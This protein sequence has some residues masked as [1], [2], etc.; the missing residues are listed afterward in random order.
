MNTRS[1][2]LSSQPA[3]SEPSI[4][5]SAPAT[6]ALAMSPEYCSP[7]SP[8]TG[9][10]A[11]LARLRRL[12]DRGHL[13]H[14]D[15]GDHAGGADRAGPDADLHAVRPGVDQRLRAASRVATLPPTTSTSRARR[16]RPSA[17]R[18]CP[19]RRVEWPFAV[20]TTSTST[21]ASTSAIARFQ[22]SSKKPIA[23]PT[24]SRPAGSLVASGYCSL[25]VKS[26]TVIRPLQPAR[27]VDQRQLLDLVLGAAARIA[28]VA[29]DADRGR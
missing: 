9:T 19:A 16:A 13:R 6:S 20:S 7:P 1:P 11:G 2:G 18:S 17:A 27:V 5:V 25:L 4:T 3:S 22:A 10:P 14:A 23:A 15:T 24:R 8:I 21:P 29:V 12:V 26:L 28:V